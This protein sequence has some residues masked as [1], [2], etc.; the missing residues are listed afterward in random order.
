MSKKA[1][2]TRR[3]KIAAPAAALRA[4]IA[5]FFAARLGWKQSTAVFHTTAKRNLSMIFD[6]DGTKCHGFAG[7]ITKSTLMPSR[8]TTT[9]KAMAAHGEITAP[10]VRSVLMSPSPAANEEHRCSGEQVVGAR[11]HI[12]KCCVLHTQRLLCR[13]VGKL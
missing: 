5:E 3:K 10:F 11:P 4:T 1:R 8:T 13:V 2:P 7:Q 6:A 12:R 9:S